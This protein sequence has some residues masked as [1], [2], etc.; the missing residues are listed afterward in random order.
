MA[1]TRA[2]DFMRLPAGYNNHVRQD[3]NLP[4]NPRMPNVIETRD[5]PAMTD[6][7][8]DLLTIK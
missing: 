7:V 8:E 3:E 4:V 1:L 5:L 6:V 2:C